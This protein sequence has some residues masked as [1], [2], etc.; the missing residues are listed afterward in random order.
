MNSFS[1]T[2]TLA[3]KS[4]NANVSQAGALNTPWTVA[5]KADVFEF[6]ER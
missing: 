5:T 3:A 4:W 1:F 2:G 6:E